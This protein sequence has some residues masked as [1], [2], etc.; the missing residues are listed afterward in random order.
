M[1]FGDAVR[2]E[3]D[4]RPGLVRHGWVFGLPPYSAGYHDV[5]MAAGDTWIGMPVNVRWCEVTGNDEAKAVA[6]RDRFE[7]DYPKWLRPITVS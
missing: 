7:A 6:L 4:D 5:V 1:K 2:I 3:I